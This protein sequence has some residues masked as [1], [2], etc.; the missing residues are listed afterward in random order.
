M[1]DPEPSERDASA[2]PDPQD[3]QQPHTRD[4][5]PVGCSFAGGAAVP[6]LALL[7]LALVLLRRR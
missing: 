3:P 5:T 2:A 4:R 1:P 7:A 6:W